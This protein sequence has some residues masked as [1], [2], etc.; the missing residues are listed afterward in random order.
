MRTLTREDACLSNYALDRWFV[1]QLSA[2]EAR[3]MQEHMDG[4][5]HCSLRC[6]ELSRQRSAFYTRAPSW[7]AFEK[8]RSPAPV[9]PSRAR[10]RAASAPGVRAWALPLMAA[11]GLLVIGVGVGLRSS[12][13]QQSATERSKGGP[14][15]GFFVKRGERIRRGSTSEEVIPGELLRFTYTT[16]RPLYFALLHADSA[17][18]KIQFPTQPNAARIEAGREIPL[19]FSI[20]LDSLLGTERVYGVFCEEAIALEPVR[21]GLERSGSLP[22]LPRCRVDPLELKKR[23][24]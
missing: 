2:D 20:R 15:I 16:E 13:P 22:L 9:L 5:P 11:A 21:A 19:D 18:A 14:S 4:C 23:S 10:R 12:E 1:G 7:G 6:D 8:L 24:P 17:G 3:A